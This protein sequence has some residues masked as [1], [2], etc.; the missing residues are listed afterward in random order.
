LWNVVRLAVKTGYLLA[1]TRQREIKDWAISFQ[2]CLYSHFL[3]KSVHA[4]PHRRTHHGILGAAGK[5]SHLDGGTVTLQIPL[6]VDQLFL[7][8]ANQTPEA[9]VQSGSGAKTLEEWLTRAGLRLRPQNVTAAPEAQVEGPH[10]LPG[11][12]ASPEP[13]GVGQRDPTSPD[14]AA[15]KDSG[16]TRSI[17]VDGMRTTVVEF[18]SLLQGLISTRVSRPFASL[19]WWFVALKWI[20]LRRQIR[21]YIQDSAQK[22][23]Q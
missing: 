4:S 7:V 9:S 6:S 22:G 14:R 21:G 8:G 11:T 15:A 13:A 16:E 12:E 18:Q 23:K 19:W 10:Q 3:T 17:T 20:L 5:H 1:R 2:Y